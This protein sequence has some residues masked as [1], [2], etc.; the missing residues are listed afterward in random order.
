MVIFTY[1][2]RIPSKEQESFSK[3]WQEL[4]EVVIKKYGVSNASLYTTDNGDRVA[5]V[6]WPSVEAWERWKTELADNPLRQKYRPYRISRPEIL[7]PLVI[8]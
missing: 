4:T 6:T 2:W 1:R 8:L 5:I 7:T 3:D